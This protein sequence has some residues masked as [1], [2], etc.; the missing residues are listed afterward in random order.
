MQSKK[1]LRKEYLQKR[2]NL[3]EGD[4]Q[5]KNSRIADKL[6][7]FFSFEKIESVHIFLPI[8]KHREVN[9]N[10][11][12][13]KIQREYPHIKI[14]VS[15]SDL[16]NFGMSHY[17]LDQN[18]LLL[19]NKWGIPE[20]A[21]GLPFPEKDLDMVLVP[22]V[23]FDKEGHRVG[24]GKGFYDRFLRKCRINAIKVGLALE[25]PVDLIPDIHENDFKMD[26]CVT[27]EKIYDFKD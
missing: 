13:K 11:I 22:L 10:L 7:S 21:N 23:A 16:E 19:E 14:I 18:T 26:Y 12:I 6:F 5:E 25:Q 1:A 15:K 24:Y 8:L 27:P 9:T 3:S 20:P 2:Q 4:Y 17:I